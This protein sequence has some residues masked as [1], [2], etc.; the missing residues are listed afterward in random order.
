MPVMN[1]LSIVP[2]VSMTAYVQLST[3]QTLEL[4]FRRGE[5]GQAMLASHVHMQNDQGR[6]SLRCMVSHLRGKVLVQA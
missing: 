1:Q 6:I 4:D 2:L 3:H 5:G